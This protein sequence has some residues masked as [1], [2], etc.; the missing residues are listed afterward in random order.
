M[1]TEAQP[2]PNLDIDDEQLQSQAPKTRSRGAYRGR[3][4]AGNAHYLSFVGKFTGADLEAFSVLRNREPNKFTDDEGLPSLGGTDKRL[5]KLV[6]LGALD[7][8][9]DPAVGKNI[10]GLSQAGSSYAEEFG[11]DMSHTASLHGKAKS[12]LRHYRLIAHVAAQFHSPEGFF[13]DTLGINPVPLDN[14][15]P[16]QEMIAPYKKIEKQLRIQAGK[17]GTADFGKWRVEQLKAALQKVKAD[18]LHW[19]DLVEA[20]PILLTVGHPQRE[21][22]KLKQVHQCD[23]AV[24]LENERTDA[25]SKNLLVEVELHKK[26]WE[27]YDRILATL[28]AELDKPYIYSRAVYFTVGNEVP[29]RLKK[30]DASGAYNLISDGKLVILPILDRDGV[31]VGTK[32]TEYNSRVMIGGNAS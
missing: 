11:Y 25:R 7:R 21:G 32:S 28:K 22:S 10:Y 1:T 13:K 15:I 23:M 24:I 19:S 20:Y 14:L 26:S 3:V 12:R 27:D 4:T 9:R 5:R 29:N 18:E 31:E 30:V 17:D 6:K 16:E 8:V 2:L